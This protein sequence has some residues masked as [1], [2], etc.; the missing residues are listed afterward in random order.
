M[1]K[2]LLL[3]VVIALFAFTSSND[4]SLASVEQKEGYYIFLLSKPVQKTEYLGSVKKG[5]ALS[6]EP[7]EMLNSIIKKVKK[8]YP[9]A[10]AIIFTSIDMSK[11]D[12]VKFKE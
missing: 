2:L 8:E 5:M 4:N 3:S 6:G 10:D 7:E 11:A 1:K 12:A 9:K